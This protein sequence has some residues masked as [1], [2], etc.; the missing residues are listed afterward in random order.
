[1]RGVR[2]MPETE[3]IG[4]PLKPVAAVATYDD[5]AEALAEL[6][7]L[8]SG[9]GEFDT[10]WSDEHVEG[11]ASGVDR[12]LLKKLRRGA[13]SLRGHLDLHGYTRADARILV[14]Q[15]LEARRRVGDRCVL[16]VHGRGLHSK[17][18]IPVL[19]QAVSSWLY[20]G[21]IARMVLAFCSARPEDGGLGALYVLLR[22]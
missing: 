9:Q 4:P 14:K 6:A 17:D 2:R 3:R 20:G 22:K 15:F 16:I 7:D 19:K 1:M 21:G 11:V 18:G 13:F 10:V 12:R 8:V 5:E